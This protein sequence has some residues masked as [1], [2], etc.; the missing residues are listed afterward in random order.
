VDCTLRDGEQ[1]P[2]LAFS[3]SD[4]VEIAKA[5]DR[6][7]VYE[8]EAGMPAVSTEDFEAV[9][10]IVTANLTAKI[11]GLARAMKSD[12]DLVKKTGCWG[13]R[14]SLP[15]SPLQRQ[16][17]L[18]KTDDEVLEMALKSAELARESGLY[19]IFSPYDTTR[20]DF[21]FLVRLVSDLSK[22]K[23]VDR[24]RL[25]DTVGAALPSAVQ[26]LVHVMLDASEGVPVEIHTHNDFGLALASTLEGVMAGSEYVSCTINGLGSRCGN[27]ALEE[28]VVALEL[29]CRIKTNI[30]AALLTEVSQLV[31]RLSHVKVAPQKAVV[32]MNAFSHETGLTVAGVLN[33][34]FVAEA[35][36]PA[37]VG[38]KRSIVL[39]KKSG[40]ASVVEALASHKLQA[41]P[42]QVREILAEVKQKAIHCERSITDDEFMAIVDHKL[43]SIS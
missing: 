34:P 2:G 30:N 1:Q 21:A 31:E 36:D 7:G 8:I 18:R 27:T 12:I 33:N 11:S 29:L 24:F 16:Y 19:V 42:E 40:A 6:L 4:K 14:I 9:S 20:C 35:Y 39:G 23:L 15:A 43:Q 38:Q 5:L 10:E 37:L 41:T 28:T 13:L 3:K 32:G 22:R 17:K 26:Y 25:V